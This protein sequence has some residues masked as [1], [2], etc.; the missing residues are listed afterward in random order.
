[1]VPHGHANIALAFHYNCFKEMRENTLY[2]LTVLNKLQEQTKLIEM[3]IIFKLSK[4]LL[5]NILLSQLP[6]MVNLIFRLVIN[7]LPKMK[8]LN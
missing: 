6:K 2:K 4:H 3:D 5:N 7:L 8:I 1:M